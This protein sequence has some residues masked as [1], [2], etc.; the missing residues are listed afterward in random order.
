MRKYDKSCLHF[1]PFLL[2]LQGRILPPKPAPQMHDLSLK[3]LLDAPSIVA[4]I[5]LVPMSVKDA[6]D[7]CLLLGILTLGFF[8]HAL[9]IVIVPLASP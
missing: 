7:S 2:S 5:I 4:G 3:L 8:G 1:P 6:L 9:P